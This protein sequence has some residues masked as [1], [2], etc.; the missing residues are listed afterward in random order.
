MEQLLLVRAKTIYMFFGIFLKGI[1]MK[2]GLNLKS[3]DD[4]GIL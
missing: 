4:D 2:R 3:K 1:Q